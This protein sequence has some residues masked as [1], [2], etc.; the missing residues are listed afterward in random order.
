MPPRQQRTTAAALAAAAPLAEEPNLHSPPPVTPG[1][2]VEE[3]LDQDNTAD[4]VTRGEEKTPE[5]DT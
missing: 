2:E 4:D 1:N 5:G 3:T